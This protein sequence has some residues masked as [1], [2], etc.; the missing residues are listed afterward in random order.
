[1]VAIGSIGYPNW[2]LAFGAGIQEWGVHQII[3]LHCTVSL[4]RMLLYAFLMH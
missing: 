3:V 1:M 4:L 2:H